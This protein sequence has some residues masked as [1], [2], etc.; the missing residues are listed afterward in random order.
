LSQGKNSVQISLL[1]LAMQQTAEI[2]INVCFTPTG[3]HNDMQL[4]TKQ[5]IVS[6]QLI[7]CPVPS[8][9]RG[10]TPVHRDVLLVG[11]GS[12]LGTPHSGKRGCIG[13]LMAALMGRLAFKVVTHS[14]DT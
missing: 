7:T 8:A 3:F 12:S 11:S 4:D 6:D 5:V 9:V 2:N 13:N 10:V 1:L 14:Y